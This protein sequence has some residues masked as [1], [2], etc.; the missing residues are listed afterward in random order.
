[1]HRLDNHSLNIDRILGH[2][3]WALLILLAFTHFA[4]RE[5]DKYPPTVDEFRAMYN[6]GWIVD[7]RY[8]PVDVLASLARNSPDQTPL[9]YVLLN[10][11]GLFTSEDIAIARVLSVF[12]AVLT[13]AMLF[14][15][16]SD[17]VAPV[18]GTMAL[19]ISASNV[20]LNFHAPNARMYALLM[21]ASVWALWL[22]LRVMFRVRAPRWRDYAALALACFVLASAHAA[23]SFLFLAV[24]LYH[25]AAAP[26][27]TRWWRVAASV[28]A[29]ILLFSPWLIILSNSGIPDFGRYSLHT[30]NESSAILATM[31]VL[32]LNN[33]M[34]L[35]LI[36]LVG[37][38]IAW[39]RRQISIRSY[40][41]IAIY[42]FAVL[43]ILEQTVGLLSEY[44]LRYIQ[45]GFLLFFYLTATGMVALYR[46]RRWT[47]ILAVAFVA[48]GLVYQQ[49]GQWF[50]LVQTR[51]QQMRQIP[52]QAIGRILDSATEKPDI[53]YVYRSLTYMLDKE[54]GSI[55]HHDYYLDDIDVVNHND[56]S[57]FAR[58]AQSHALTTPSLWLAYHESALEQAEPRALATA[59]K[60]MEYV[61]C[62]RNELA[63]D[64]V[65]LQYG[66]RALACDAPRQMLSA[67]N[68]LIDYQLFGVE[69]N[70]SGTA[71][72][73]SDE[74]QGRN[75]APIQ[76]YKMSYQLIGN[77]WDNV[78]QL[79]LPLIHEGVPRQFSIDISEV[80]AGRYQLLA[81]FYDQETGERVSWDEAEATNPQMLRLTELEL[82]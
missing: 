71:L 55:R 19:I 73:F 76:Q 56:V 42:Y 28:I 21:F 66:W 24:G 31:L 3:I 59:L 1:M 44:R 57:Y 69:R 14:R 80:P 82:P 48:A 78:A 46:F 43:L 16:A 62:E 64:A 54:F 33:S 61:L 15:L 60:S 50:Q 2:W 77:G 81:V 40:H 74:W 39:R 4:V 72:V 27:G 34:F 53:I 49:S 13:H 20:F 18:G 41:L 11:W 26:K 6:V 51:R 17:F 23:S 36:P 25:V 22:Y 7:D 35:L 63:G 32:L 8:S 75:T 9:Y 29:S 38:S 5:I 58:S 70:E 30:S 47:I 65:L 37:I 45:P 68:S 67:S 10:V 12:F 79:D 52:Y